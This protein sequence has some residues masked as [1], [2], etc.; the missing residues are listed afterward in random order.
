MRKCEFAEGE[1]VL[2]AKID[3]AAG[4]IN[5]R[6]PIIYR[7]LHA[8]HPHTGDKWCIYPMYD[9]AHCLSD[10]I[11]QIT[12]SLCTLEF[13]DHRPLYDWFVQKLVHESVHPEQTEFSKLMLSHTLMSKR[14]LKKMVDAGLVTA[15]DDPRM[16]TLSGVR[17]R[18]YPA[19]AIKNFCAQAGMSKSESI[20]DLS[21]L[22]EA[23]RD[24]L[25]NTAPRIMAV[26]DPILVTIY[27][28]EPDY[29]VELK[30][31]INQNIP[32]LGMRKISFSRQIY[33][34]RNDFMEHP[35]KKF[36]RLSYGT[37]V[38]L[39]YSYIIK[40]E[41]IIKDVNGIIK[42][43]ICSHD[44]TTLGKNPPDRK[45]KGVIHW[46]CAKNNISAQINVFDRLFKES[47]PHKA[48]DWDELL[49]FINSDSI[50]IIPQAFIEKSWADYSFEQAAQPFQFERLGYFVLDKQ[51]SIDSNLVFNKTVGLKDSWDKIK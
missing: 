10:A 25:N 43:L 2:R 49:S 34:E 9:F 30:A 51:E 24:E 8:V 17:R 28:L 27:D 21:L 42:E 46:V 7:I 39:R 6:D 38:R 20:L 18:G 35:T 13:Q 26:L 15:W 14:N 11:E 19:Q 45:V 40:C 47:H 5:M 12:H 16:P 44:A 48:Q 50:K 32:E 33:I 4:N 36:H 29:E 23:V 37:E 22:E 31:A 41:K 1:H 3:M